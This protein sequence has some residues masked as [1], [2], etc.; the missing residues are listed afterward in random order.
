LI[1][2]GC[3]V[4]ENTLDEQ[5]RKNKLIQ[6]I[7]QLDKTHLHTTYLVV[8]KLQGHQESTSLKTVQCSWKAP[9][10]VPAPILLLP[11]LPT[12]IWHNLKVFMLLSFL[13]WM[14]IKKIKII[15]TIHVVKII[16]QNRVSAKKL[17]RL[18][19]P[20]RSWHHNSKRQRT[21]AVNKT[22]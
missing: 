9:W 2:V 12:N 3:S 4:K 7:E 5:I 20:I 21:L 8:W 6:I 13:R 19:K 1:I 22:K 15:K 16:R 17:I 11:F 18:S 10:A 14:I